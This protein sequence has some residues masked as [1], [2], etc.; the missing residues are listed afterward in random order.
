MIKFIKPIVFFDLETTGTDPNNDRIA[1]IACI[2]ITPDDTPQGTREEKVMLINPTVPI[3]EEATKIH[4]IT[5]EMVKDAPMFKNIA[6]GLLAFMFGCDLSGYNSDGFDIPMLMK[7]FERCG[8]AFPTWELTCLDVMKY[9]KHL[10]PNKLSD[11]YFRYTGNV[12]EGA[13]DALQDIRA[14]LTVLEH[15][16]KEGEDLTANDVA[17]LYRDGKDLFDIAGKCYL[18]EGVV[19]WNFGKNKDKDIMQDIRYLEWSLNSKPPYELPAQ[20]KEKL[21][22]YLKSK[23]NA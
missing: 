17:L 9:E 14:T 2:K 22:E 13:H 8:I 23:K 5:N 4:G 18:E 12:L 1:Q 15:Q 6:K 19:K 10:N 11:V 21:T 16:T 20:T 3:P 7:E